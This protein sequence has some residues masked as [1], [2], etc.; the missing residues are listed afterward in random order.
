VGRRALSAGLFYKT[1][2]MSEST[3][4]K[5]ITA[6]SIRFTGSIAARCARRP[7]STASRIC[8]R[9]QAR[10]R[11]SEEAQRGDRDPPRCRPNNQYEPGYLG[12]KGKPV[13]SLYIEVGEKHLISRKGFHSMPD[14][15]FA[16]HHRAAR[17]IRPLAGDENAGDGQGHQHNGAHDPRRRQPR[18]RS[19]A[20][21]SRGQRH[22]QDRQPPWRQRPPAA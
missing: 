4:P 11:G 7:T 5:T 9:R 22:Y 8:R 10:F 1:L 3:S 12:V 20:A 13:E 17:R 6:A 14:P 16:P 21:P 15:G 19:A 2:H 18:R